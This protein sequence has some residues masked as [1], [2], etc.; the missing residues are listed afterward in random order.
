MIKAIKIRLK[1]TKE[2]EILM[3]KSVG[4]ARFVFNWGLSKWEEMYKEGL[5]PNG[6]KIKKIFNNTIKKEEQYKWLTEVSSQL[7]S[8]TFNDLQ[9]S[10]DNFFD[11]KAKY[12][13]FKTKKRSKNS[14][15][16]RYDRMNIKDDTVNIEK[17]GRVEFTTNYNIPILKAYVNP[18]CHFDG[19]YWY[20]TF[21]FEQ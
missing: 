7:I 3:N 16:V 6:K 20:L 19:K 8:E 11:G 12:P 13:R 9:K 18:R 5:K 14:F 15:Y 17:I 4:V 10:F 21:G 1:P 2:Q